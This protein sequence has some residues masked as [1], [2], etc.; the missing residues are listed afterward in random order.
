MNACL[1]P[2]CSMHGLAVTTVEGIGTTKTRLHPV[3]ERIAK[4]HGSQCGFCTVGIVMSMYTL[5]RNN[6]K[7]TMHD[8]E[9]TFQ[10][11]LCRCTGYR[12][13]IEGYRSFTSEG[14]SAK[15]CCKK[16][17]FDCKS[18]ANPL[19]EKSQFQPYDPTQEPIFPS[20]LK[21]FTDLD[22]QALSFGGKEARWFRPIKLC[23]LLGLKNQYPEAKLVVGNT[24][25]GVE[26]KFKK[27]H[28][29]V[30]IQTNYIPELT[31][32]TV[33]ECGIRVGASATLQQMETVLRQQMKVKS[34]YRTRIFAALIDMLHYFAGKQIRNVAAVGGN[35]MT[36]S[37]ISDLNP[38]F[39]AANCMLE[40][41]SKARGFRSIKMDDTFFTGYRK[42]QV[43]NDEVLIAINI[44]FT[45]MNQYFYAYKQAKRRDDDIAIV[46]MAVNV[47][48]DDNKISDIRLA[49]G[50]MAPITV[51]ARKTRNALIGT[52]WDEKML[53]KAYDFL[54][55]DLPL[56]PDAP[57]GM[58][59]Y[60]RSLTLSMFF[61]AYLA[62]S[63]Q[64]DKELPES[65]KSGIRG[66]KYV[67]PKS[68]QYFQ[69]VQ[70]DNDTDMV[71]RPVVHASALKQASGEAIYCDDIPSPAGELYAGLV[72]STRSHA[73]IV[74]VDPTEALKY[75]GVHGF[76]GAK[77]LTPEQNKHGMID[78]EEIFASKKVTSQGQVIAI[79][80]ADDQLIAQKAARKV[81]VEYKNL[82]P[83]IVTIEDA[84]KHESFFQ[85]VTMENGK[86]DQAL[87]ES[88]HVVEGECRLGAQEHFYLET[89][90]TVAVPKLEDDEM[91]IFSS[92]QNPTEVG[93]HV[94]H[95]L[96]IPINR[97]VCKAKRLGGGFGGKE[98][99]ASLLALPVAL[100]AYRLRRPVRCMLD[101]DEDVIMTGQRH[102]FLMKY[103]TGFTSRGKIT[104]CEI[105]LYSNCGYSLDLSIGV[106]ER[107]MFHFQNAYKIP[108]SRVFGYPCKTN[109]PSNTAFRGF[110]GPQGMF[111]AEMMIRDIAEYL[112]KDPV[113]IS[114][115]NLYQEGD[116]THY[117]QQLTYC[118]LQ[119]CWD[120]CLQR[121]DYKN[122]KKEVEEFNR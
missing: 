84:I 75:E 95:M 73:E 81:K 18:D 26:V 25:I 22:T 86:V 67:T 90:C 51:A 82:E 9:E 66:F 12:S 100:A 121:S 14:C 68:S 34:L 6:P 78:D 94:A 116:F 21:L 7:P 119:R 27:M 102:P 4:A 10:G 107:A 99:K 76:F 65:Y 47:T 113:E 93:N 36:S 98:S 16:A 74:S 53:E 105:Y 87:K 108:N 106:L 39:L 8:L 35:I 109:L 85:T 64:L 33:S 97:V 79:V 44:P 15:D 114:Q 29:P 52:E 60:R 111:A 112:R 122:A 42:N 104:S 37:P 88:D 1:A 71:G 19:F 30:L 3:Q 77:D 58:I 89:H 41:S 5:L 62:I 117:N 20:E 17:G 56:S 83:V 23:N 48:V 38:I 24:E 110:G 11:N 120:E 32:I 45:K 70:N 46:N 72:L 2:L 92:T 13:I 31:D 80:V 61:R 69:I 91:E 40:V 49:F 118:T 96:G 115:L 28:Y 43:K 57:G 55:E 101:R 63:Q 103:K 50:G 59:L 54:I